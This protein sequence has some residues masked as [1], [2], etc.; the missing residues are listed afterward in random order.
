MLRT[1]HSLIAD[2]AEQLGA[3]LA[4]KKIAFPLLHVDF[5]AARA[6]RTELNIDIGT[7]TQSHMLLNQVVGQR[8]RQK[9]A[10]FS[11]MLRVLLEVHLSFSF[12]STRPA[13]PREAA[14]ALD[15]SAAALIF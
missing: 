8:R 3:P 14:G 1:F 4:R 10:F 5:F 9:R 11:Q 13:D 15:M 12:T 7:L 6:A 2:E